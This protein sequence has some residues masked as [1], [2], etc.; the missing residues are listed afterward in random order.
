MSD[1][2]TRGLRRLGAIMAPPTL[3]PAVLAAAGIAAADAYS[4]LE[5]ELGSVFIAY[6]AAG[7]SAVMR[8]NDEGEF[9]KWFAA[10]FQRPLRREPEPPARLRR[11]LGERLTRSGAGNLRFDLHDLTPFERDVLLKTLEIP[12]GEVRTYGWIAR[13]IGRPGAVRAVGTALGHNP[14]PYLIPC[15][16]VVR[17]DGHLGQYSAGGPEAKRRVLSLEGL[18]P[19]QLEEMAR[20]GVRYHGSDTTR[21]FCFPTCRNARRITHSHRVD[22]HSQGAALAAGYRPCRVC[23]PALVA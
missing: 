23:R 16:R 4:Q 17:S 22:F 9:L 15:H 12:R 8:A 21:V 18:D 2:L 3:L 14:I 19:D 7:I 13:E 6:N 11:A 20:A 10:R 1:Q 5:S